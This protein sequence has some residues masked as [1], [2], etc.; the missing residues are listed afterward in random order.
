MKD[1]KFGLKPAP[2]NPIVASVKIKIAPPAP[3][4][5]PLPEKK[6]VQET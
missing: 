2:G 4:P 3:R 5:T 6:I 1:K